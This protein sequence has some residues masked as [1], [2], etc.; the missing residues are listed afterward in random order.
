MA[1]GMISERAAISI[2]DMLDNCV[3]VQP[4]QHVL[5]VAAVDGL[6][7]GRNYVDEYSVNWIQQAIQARRAYA[8]VLWLNMPLHA[9]VYWN[10]TNNEIPRWELP[11]VFTKAIEGADLVIGQMIDLWT[12]GELKDSRP[13]NF[14]YNMAT[15][16][17]LL[18]SAWALT[19]W[20]LVAE[21]RYQAAMNIK[22]GARWSITH[23]NGTNVSG[24]IGKPMAHMFQRRR[25]PFPEGVFPSTPTDD[26]EGVVIFE[27]TGPNWARHIGMPTTFSE[28][29]RIT[30][31]DGMIKEIEGGA[32][33]ETLRDFLKSL[34][35][36]LGDMAYKMRGFHGG[37]HPHARVSEAECPD[38][39]YRSFIEHHGAHSVHVHLADSHLAENYPFNVHI[40]AEVNGA[41]M[42]IGDNV[43]YE[44]GRLTAFDHPE[45]QRIAAKYPDR[46]GVSGA[47]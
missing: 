26:A 24:T 1:A 23:P 37:A 2:A 15:T 6:Y 32:E 33:A 31:E 18:A 38:P 34:S 13:P 20:E 30:L 8:S 44:N 17:P 42:K 46:P 35:H 21:I 16:A 27:H 3:P 4:G 41:T 36:H 5:I 7:G 43:V 9:D 40:S 39:M 29:V 14:L 28:P 12:E 10:R 11:P 22:Q 25:G 47:W 45:V 19:P